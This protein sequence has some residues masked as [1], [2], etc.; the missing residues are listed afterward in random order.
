MW[1]NTAENATRGANAADKAI[2]SS[3][4]KAGV[5]PHFNDRRRKVLWEC[6]K[7]RRFF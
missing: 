4:R 5:F 1:K 2:Q 3:K 6:G 7:V